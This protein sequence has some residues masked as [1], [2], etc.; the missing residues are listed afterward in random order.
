MP[1]AAARHKQCDKS[2]A[3]P[4]IGIADR[5]DRVFAPLHAALQIDEC[6]LRN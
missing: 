5:A 1:T 6:N 3:G 2:A 4:E